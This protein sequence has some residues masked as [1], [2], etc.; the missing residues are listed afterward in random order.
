M[1]SLQEI[2]Q[3]QNPKPSTSPYQHVLPPGPSEILFIS[4]DHQVFQHPEV[5]GMILSSPSAPLLLLP[6]PTSDASPEFA[7]LAG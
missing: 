7:V 2:E 4:Q 1:D 5:P 3:T 6:I